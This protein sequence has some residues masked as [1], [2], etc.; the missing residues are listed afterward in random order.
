M[1]YHIQPCTCS[2][3]ESFSV[4]NFSKLFIILASVSNGLCS[5][6]WQKHL[7]FLVNT[8]PKLVSLQVCNLL[9]FN[10]HF[11]RVSW[12]RYMTNGLW[13]ILDVH[14]V[15][16]VRLTLKQHSK[17]NQSWSISVMTLWMLEILTNTGYE[18]QLSVQHRQKNTM[19]EWKQNSA[20]L[21]RTF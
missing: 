7:H 4:E 3:S 9:T 5:E 14:N 10:I 20:F 8:E 13:V 12:V 19:D 6:A 17:A 16:A 11:F 15:I 18:I 1:L 2:G 21:K